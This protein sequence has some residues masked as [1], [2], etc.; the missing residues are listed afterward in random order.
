MGIFLVAQDM[1]LSHRAKFQLIMNFF[2]VSKYF[3][4]FLPDYKVFFTLQQYFRFGLNVTVV[5]SPEFAKIHWHGRH[6][7]DLDWN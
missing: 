6:P 3:V 1:V 7:E 2:R 5:R 4:V